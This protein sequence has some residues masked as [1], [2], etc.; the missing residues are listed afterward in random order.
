M[1][2]DDLNDAV[3]A[4]GFPHSAPGAQTRA[5]VRAALAVLDTDHTVTC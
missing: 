5:S 3:H 2:V 1:T 4:L